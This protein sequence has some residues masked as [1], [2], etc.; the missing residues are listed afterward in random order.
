MTFRDQ[1]ARGVDRADTRSR[2]VLQVD[3]GRSGS[4]GRQHQALFDLVRHLDRS[5]YQPVLR[6]EWNKNGK[7]RFLAYVKESRRPAND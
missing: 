5:R 7:K 2:P 3:V 6:L 4:A 1:G